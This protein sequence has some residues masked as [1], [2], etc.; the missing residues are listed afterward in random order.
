MFHKRNFIIIGLW[1]G[2][3]LTADQ[4]WQRWRE[5]L[6]IWASK[7]NYV[8]RPSDTLPGLWNVFHRNKNTVTRM[9]PWWHTWLGPIVALEQVIKRLWEAMRGILYG[10]WRGG[11][12]FMVRTTFA[13]A[14]LLPSN[15]SRNPVRPPHRL[16]V[17]HSLL[18]WQ[19][20]SHSLIVAKK[21]AV[22]VIGLIWGNFSIPMSRNCV[23]TFTM[24]RH[25]DDKNP[26]QRL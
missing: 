19:K 15:L 11:K 14:A 25:T 7:G 4:N 23:H 26:T 2:T 9:L 22:C 8:L 21:G 17:A 13:P 24:H 12:D 1:R 20:K 6:E 5:N 3:F 10:N 16:G 18:W